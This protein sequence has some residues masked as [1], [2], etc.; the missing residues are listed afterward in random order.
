MT[1]TE[2]A[3]VDPSSAARQRRLKIIR[4]VSA[5]VTLVAVAAL[6]FMAVAG[7]HTVHKHTTVV[8][9]VES[10]ARQTPVAPPSDPATATQSTSSSAGGSSLITSPPLS[11]SVAPAVTSPEVVTAASTTTATS[12]PAPTSAAPTGP[13][14]P[15]PAA[16]VACPLSLPAP[17]QTGGLQSLIALS[18]LFGPFSAEAFAS[19]AAFQPVLELFGPFLIEFASAYATAEPSLAPLVSQVEALEN[20]GFSVISPF[21]LPYRT[22]F[23]TAETALATALAPYAEA[24]VSSPAA[25]CLIDVEGVL[26][27]AGSK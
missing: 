15:A 18:P 24:L 17:A 4:V 6:G 3:S 27:S 22:K 20:E 12:T 13:A 10:A 26:T 25:S 21:Y 8:K 14:A 16:L 1:L 5:F 7:A 23:L 11:A 2:A 9:K 19:A